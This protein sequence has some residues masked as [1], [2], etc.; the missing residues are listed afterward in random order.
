MTPSKMSLAEFET[1]LGSIISR[2][3]RLR[4]F[5]ADGSP[6]ECQ[7][8]VVGHNP[9]TEMNKDWWSYWN[10]RSG[11][12]KEAWF[13]AYRQERAERPLKPGRTRRNAVSATRRVLTWIEDAASPVKCLETNIYP[14]PTPTAAE[15]GRKDKDAT[16]LGFL[17]S[18]I[19]PSIIV[20]HGVPAIEEVGKLAGVTFGI[21]ESR[22][23]SVAGH[24][25]R[26]IGVAHF[27]RGWS[28]ERATRF[29]QELRALTARRSAS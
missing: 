14:T 24:T 27:S 7:V 17:L 11:F 20:A 21:G 13:A 3:T 6:V 22:L 26:I 8:F 23:G 28:R 10:S 12:D 4:A 9:A 25:T 5:V 29:G 15:L 18:A 1:R 19:R 16:V 2:P